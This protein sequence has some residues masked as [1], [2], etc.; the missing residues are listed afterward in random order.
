MF[1]LTEQQRE[2]LSARMALEYTSK[3]QKSPS[4]KG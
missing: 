4:Q 3:K 1:R 2:Q